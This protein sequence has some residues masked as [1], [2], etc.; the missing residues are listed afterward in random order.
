MHN[1]G[2]NVSKLRRSLHIGH[3]S[4]HYI[5]MIVTSVVDQ[6]KSDDERGMVVFLRNNHV[7]TT[8]DLLSRVDAALIYDLAVSSI[9]GLVYHSV[10]H[11]LSESSRLTAFSCMLTFALHNACV[12]RL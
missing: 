8:W 5:V 2:G 6:S 11:L 1:C 4:T 7:V 3:F 12:I 9:F 10:V